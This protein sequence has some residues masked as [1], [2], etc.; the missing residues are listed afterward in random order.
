M[1]KI[2]LYFIFFITLNALGQIDSDLSGSNAQKFDE[3][4]RYISKLYVDSIDQDDL[5]NAAIISMLEELDPHSSYISKEEVAEAN[6]SI[7]GSFVGIGIRYQILRDTLL[8]I[9]TI[10]GGPSE[11]IGIKSGDKIISVNDENI[12]GVGLK[13][14]Q[15]KEKLMGELGTKVTVDIL[16]KNANKKMKF[17]IARDNIPIYSVDASNNWIY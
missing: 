6:S 2:A 8:V 11:K 4:L 3:I 10:P 1:K 13:T 14:N 15:V 17:V 9:A 16:R 5:T 12:A 7:N